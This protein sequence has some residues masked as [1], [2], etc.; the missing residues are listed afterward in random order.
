MAIPINWWAL[1]VTTLVSFIAGFLWFGPV[2]GK[3]WMKTLGI[4]MPETITPE[5]KKGMIRGY[6][7][8]AIGA[9]ITNFVLLHNITFG[10][11]Y[12]HITGIAAG[13]QAAFWNWL[14]FVA[15]ATLGAVLWEGRPFKHWVITAGYYLVTLAI[16]GMILASWM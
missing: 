3:A 8:V 5:M 11:Q 9:L 1:I 2:F 7:I 13:L 10:A 4:S 14:G 6:I 15:P 12:L 16:N